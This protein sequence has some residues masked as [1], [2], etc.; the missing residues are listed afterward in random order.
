[1][2]EERVKRKISAIFSADVEGYSRLMGDDEVATVRTLENYRNI[3]VDLIEQHRG[4]VVDS[5]GDNLLAEFGSVVDAVQCAVEVQQVLKAKNGELPENRRM[6]FR[7]GVN[8][9]DVIEEGERI[10][11]DGVNI[12]ARIEGLAEGGGICVSGSAYEQIENKLALGYEYLGEHAVKNITKPVRVYKVPIELGERKEKK[13]GMRRLKKVAVAA[14][15]V[16]IVGAGAFAIWNFYFRPPPIEPASVEK[17]AYPLPDKPSIA[18]MPFL[19][20]TGDRN[21]DFL[22]DGMSES[23]ITALSKLPELFVIARNTTFSYKGKAVKVAKVSEELGVRY[24][25]EGSVLKSGDRIRVTAQLIDALKGHHLWA[26]RYDREL[27]DLFAVLDDIT[28]NIITA[29]QVKLTYGESARVW[30]RGTENLEAYLKALEALW[31][32]TQ[33]T[34]EG[35]DRARQLSEKAITLDP[36][37]PTAYFVLGAVH[38][39]DALTGFSKNPKESMESSNKMFQKAIELDK[40]FAVAR[41]TRSF[42]LI[43]LRR[44]DEALAEAEQAYDLSPNNSV[45]LYYYGTLLL[46]F[47]KYEEAISPLKEALRLDPIPPQRGLRSLGCAYGWGLGQYEEA[48]AYMQRAVGRVPN[49]ILSRVILTSLFSL[50]GREEEASASAKEVLRINPKFSVDRYIRAISLKDQATSERVAQ[51]LKKAGLP[52]KPPLPLPDKPSIAVLPFVN[53]SDDKS[54]EYFSDGL[55]EEIITALSKAP[56]LFVIASNT[57]FTYKGKPVK[58]KQ[59]SEELGVRYVIE[60]SV[61]RAGERVRVTAQMIDALK[62]R[63]LWA[64]RYDK[65]FKDIFSIQDDITKKIITEVHVKLT[66]GERARVFAKGTSNLQAYLK[67][68]QADWFVNQATKDSVLRAQQLAEEAI[69]LDPNY[70]YAHMA[71]GTVHLYFVWLGISQ[72]PRDSLKRAI[73]CW[74]KAVALDPESGEAHALLANGLVMARQY[75]KAVAECERAMVLEPNSYRTLY[76]CAS[77][78]TF[79]GRREE[80][81]PLFREALRINPKPPNSLYRHYGVALRDSGRYDEAIELSKKATERKPNDMIA[82]VVLASSYGLA[83][84]EEEAKAAAKEILRINP[85]FSVDRLEKVSPH[86]DRAVAKRFCDALRKAGL[87]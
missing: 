85:K 19:N 84:R 39:M 44:Y 40:T 29:V 27:K 30:V 25:L 59:V 50:A 66:E 28:K 33:G 68:V 69:A 2:I 23:I 83:G 53:M 73:H 8:L 61:R 64:E 77:V 31:N 42:T 22:S 24:V 51:A 62:D 41:A 65:E 43:M 60:G 49:D 45:V 35:L 21:Q 79:V 46:T 14:A 17:M 67:A 4:R 76:P 52:D 71:L 34:R 70:A 11:G 47:G 81:I 10:Y 58:V 55:T 3:M 54:Q 48:I 80:A 26:D 36:K 75:D 6:Q 7:I 57:C 32:V 86:K 37:Y 74:Q 5:P 12:A 78:L 9:G 20:M 16:I 18:V 87:K 38:L 1:M 82:Y 56:Q 72:S 13:A 15:A 63:H